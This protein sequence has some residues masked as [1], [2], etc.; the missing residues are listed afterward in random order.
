VVSPGDEILMLIGSHNLLQRRAGASST[1]RGFVRFSTSSCT[2]PAGR[3]PKSAPRVPARG[4]IFVGS[5]L[6][7]RNVLYERFTT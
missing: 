3:V 1:T 5:S 2:G 4:G 6:A 7:G